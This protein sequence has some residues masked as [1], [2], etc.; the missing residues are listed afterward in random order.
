M[1]K[2]KV[3]DRINMTIQ[4]R[5]QLKKQLMQN[6]RIN[7][8]FMTG[9]GVIIALIIALGVL[10]TLNLDQLVSYSDLRETVAEIETSMMAT[11]AQQALF[12]ATND[13]AVVSD[14][15]A[16]INETVALVDHV[17]QMNITEEQTS[18]ANDMRSFII[19]YQDG[20][21]DYVDIQ[22]EKE[23]Q[24]E[25]SEAVAELV[26]DVLVT[27]MG[28]MENSIRILNDINLKTEAMNN[29]LSMETALEH[30]M[31]VRLDAN[32]YIS[33][34]SREY[35]DALN[36]NIVLM[37]AVLDQASDDIFSVNTKRK[38]EDLKIS[39]TG[40]KDSFDVYDSL[41]I[42]QHSKLDNMRLNTQSTIDAVEKLSD[43]VG[44]KIDRLEEASKLFNIILATGIILISLLA[45]R[46]I[47]VT[48]TRPLHE[49]VAHINQVADYDLTHDVSP[50][51]VTRRDEFGNL[52]RS[53]QK[54]EINLRTII[55]DIA[56]S[57]SSLAASSEQLA[58]TSS[59]SSET[60]HEVAR[61]I[62]EIAHG[63]T[64]QA[65]ST[66]QGAM[67]IDEL[68]SLLS[69]NRSFVDNL[70]S[71]ALS[72]SLLKDEGL[73]II[74]DLV[75]KTELNNEA[76]GTVHKIVTETS[77]SAEKIS[78]ASEMIKSIANQTNLLALNAAIEAARAGEAGRG[79]AV[80]AEEIRKLA[81]QTNSFTLE[82]HE[83]VDE[84]MEKASMAVQTMDAA[85]E[86]VT[87]Q[88]AG[89][90]QTNAKFE[91]I[92]GAVDEMQ[93]VI[94][95]I[96]ESAIIMNQKRDEI[97]G[98][99]ENLSAVS[100]ENAASTEEASASME[101]QTASMEQIANASN[102][103]SGLAEKMQVNVAKFKL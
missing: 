4:K 64:E 99:I 65:K 26:T 86:I 13:S 61:T 23:L 41:V 96:N 32:K 46:V 77:T 30:F 101:E 79:F 71:A 78:T 9:F 80:V 24:A 45:A 95:A 52:G 70:N 62:E 57:S 75:E 87:K 83:D 6:I 44:G 93:A 103:L 50:V 73:V 35:A 53:I 85:K 25:S 74:K 38:I 59:Q 94:N 27:L 91:G 2:K 5:K 8:K 69:S 43:S 76:S 39:L 47:T 98:V 14:F 33:N 54:I 36:E 31:R 15:D 7:R 37:N 58:A 12:E 60:A 40:Y 48:I 20:F 67:S 49:A 10:T 72:V 66:E 89:V 42:Q 51:L 68:G 18:M 56:D 3:Q 88:A 90:E 34:E 92:A 84:L 29:Y 17:L 28:D 102:E 21:H 55:G 81:E 22:G 11:T 16:K 100:E 19:T 97:I 63:A 1:S 82:I